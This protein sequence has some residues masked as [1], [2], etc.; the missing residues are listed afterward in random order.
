MAESLASDAPRQ[1]RTASKAAER[2]ARP[3]EHLLPVTAE[4]PLLLALAIDVSGSMQE[5]INSA[6]RSMR[7]GYRPSSGRLSQS[8]MAPPTGLTIRTYGRAWTWSG[9]SHTALDFEIALQT[10]AHWRH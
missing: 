6:A 8:A 5:S 4:S 9:C 1:L 7:T 2:P 10:T 3:V